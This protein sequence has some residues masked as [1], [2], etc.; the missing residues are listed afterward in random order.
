VSGVLPLGAFL[1]FHLA[2]NARAL[3][4][5]GALVATLDG[6]HRSRALA[7]T[8]AV[9]VFAPLLLHGVIGLWLVWSREPF[10]EPT[11]YSPPVLAALRGTGV[12]VALFLAMHLVE[13]RFGIAGHRPDGGALATVLAANLGATRF[14]VPWRGV[15][16]LIA[17]GCV[18]FHFVVG[19]W[20]LYAR[21]GHGQASPHRLRWAALGAA[22]AGV[23]LGVGFA[24]VVVFHATGTRLIGGSAAAAPPAHACPP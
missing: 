23:A 11:P 16:Y 2:V 17:V 3:R 13:L 14:G 8:E 18:A 7:A 6:L 10:V 12:V 1:L 4:G 15:A 22:V 19:C 20:G 24:D 9:V 5:E 21:S